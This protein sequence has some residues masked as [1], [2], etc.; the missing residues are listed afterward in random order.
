MRFTR[1]PDGCPYSPDHPTGVL[2]FTRP[3]DGCP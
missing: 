1:P 3:P 2:K